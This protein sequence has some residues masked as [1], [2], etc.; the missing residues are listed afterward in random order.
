MP[1]Q[2]RRVPRHRGKSSSGPGA[3]P[4]TLCRP[5]WLLTVS[6]SLCEPSPDCQGTRSGVRVRPPM[7]SRLWSN[8]PG[9]R[10]PGGDPRRFTQAA[11]AGYLGGAKG[12]CR[13]RG[14][15]TAGNAFEPWK[16]TGRGRNTTARDA[17][18][19]FALDQYSFKV[20]MWGSAFLWCSAARRGAQA[21]AQSLASAVTRLRDTTGAPEG[22]PC[23]GPW[24]RCAPCKGLGHSLRG[25]PCHEP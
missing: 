6:A 5:R 2:K 24:P 12:T 25:A 11:G 17:C 4:L 21:M 23:Q 16:G 1:S 18:R 3:L 14:N 10:L 20:I 19:A 15:E 7:C 13:C 8:S 22:L 9:H